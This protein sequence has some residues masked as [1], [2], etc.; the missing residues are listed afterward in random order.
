MTLSLVAA[1]EGTP[2][3]VETGIRFQTADA[4]GTH[5]FLT[6]HG[7]TVGELL[8]WPGVPPMFQARDED[9]NRFEVVAAS[10]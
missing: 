2:V 4:G 7:V 1:S 3:G 9:G 8:Q 5:R 10:R 6:D